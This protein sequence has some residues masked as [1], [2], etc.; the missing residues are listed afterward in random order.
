MSRKNIYYFVFSG[1]V[2]FLLLFKTETYK[3]FVPFNYLLIVYVH[4]IYIYQHY[5]F[6]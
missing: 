5:E 3:V 6:Y 4:D 2:I 1:Q